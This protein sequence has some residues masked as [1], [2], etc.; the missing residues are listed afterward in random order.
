MTL[1]IFHTF[2]LSYKNA[3]RVATAANENTA[4]SP[5]PI[6]FELECPDL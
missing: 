5:E 1:R 6:S 4:M 2:L 3:V